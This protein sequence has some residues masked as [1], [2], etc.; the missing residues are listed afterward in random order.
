[1]A[2]MIEKVAMMAAANDNDAAF[3]GSGNIFV[4]LGF[5]REEAERAIIAL[6]EFYAKGGRRF[7]DVKAELDHALQTQGEGE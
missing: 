3:V 2:D 4:D 6:R 7:E 1:M 5:D